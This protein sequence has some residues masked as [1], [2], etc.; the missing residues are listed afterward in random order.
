MA[1]A[2]IPRGTPA[3]PDWPKLTDV[4]VGLIDVADNVRVDVGDVSELADSI[5]EHG[6]MQPVSV[7]LAGQPGRFTLV[8]G[9]RRLAAA[10]VAGLERI[11]AIFDP[12]GMPGTASR[13][14]RQLVENLQRQDLNA[15]EEARALRG[16]LDADKKLTQAALAKRIGRSAPYVSNALRILELDRKV[17]PLVESGQ[18]SAGHAKALAGLPAD[19]QR[20]IGPLAVEAGWSVHQIEQH[21]Q[22]RREADERERKEVEALT[23]WAEQ[24]E[25]QLIE[26]GADKKAST[27]TSLD[28]YAWSSEKQLKAMKARGW[29]TTPESWSRGKQCDC[30]AFGVGQTYDHP[31]RT[32]R[33]CIVN[34]HYQAKLNAEGRRESVSY[35][36]QNRERARHE[37]EKERLH[38][39][40]TPAF[41]AAFAKLPP[42]VARI[43]LWSVM[44]YS[45]ND[46][47]KEHKGDRKKPDAWGALSDRTSTELADELVR[48]VFRDFDSRYNVKLDLAAIAAAFAVSESKPARVKKAANA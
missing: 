33:R 34:A 32:V 47:I 14:V 11:P 27:L 46:W 24:A 9:Q 35:E 26:Q 4:P 48:F 10:K 5:R 42:D 18:L 16:I 45:L 30:S 19:G 15:L 37:A 40:V 21:I 1:T 41:R 38:E 7:V 39:A 31:V 8:T 6:V 36:E 28:G 44:D 2:T 20:A 13:S 29:K 22:H 23:T 12:R 25:A 3:S 43:L 17:L